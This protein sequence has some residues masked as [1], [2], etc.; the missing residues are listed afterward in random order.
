MAKPVIYSLDAMSYQEENEI[1]FTYSGGTI[2]SS[3]IRIVEAVNNTVVYEGTQNTASTQYTLPADSVDVTTYG[4]Q[5]YIQIRITDGDGNRSS[6]SDTRFAYF[7]TTPTFQFSNVREDTV[8]KQSYL[9]ASVLYYQLEGE[10]LQD[11]I[12]Y[13]YDSS[14][15]LLLT[16]GIVYDVANLTYL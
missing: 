5:Y 11:I 1:P 7:I 3:S 9:E 15:N 13:L 8:I 4:T 6:W 12:Y 2:R 10:P 16:S 14:K